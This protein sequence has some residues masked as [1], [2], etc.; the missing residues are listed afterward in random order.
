MAPDRAIASQARPEQEFFCF[1]AGELRLAVPS[2]NV[3]EVIRTGPMTP[4]PRTPSFLL[5]VT[6]HRGEVIPVMDLLRFLGKGEARV[7]P[8]TRLFIGTSGNYRV[9]VV[10]DAV[11]GLRR[12]PVADIL[13]PPLGGDAAAEH[14]LGVYEVA[15]AQET[16]ALIHFTKL[17]Q[18]ARQR[19]VVR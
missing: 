1:R 2:E 16:M 4:L 3:L 9:G 18:S 7:G 15:S 19:A 17:L 14:L 8:R 6:G 10:A 5:G 11:L 13:P 12:V